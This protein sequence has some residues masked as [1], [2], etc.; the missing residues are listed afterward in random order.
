MVMVGLW[1]GLRIPRRCWIRGRLKPETTRCG[2]KRR[3]ANV[4]EA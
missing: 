3:E 1:I 4:K 2:Q